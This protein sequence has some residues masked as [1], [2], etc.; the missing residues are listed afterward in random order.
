M[1]IQL[2]QRHLAARRRIPHLVVRHDRW[3]DP[4]G[5]DVRMY[6]PN[7]RVLGPA[8]WDQAAHDEPAVL[9]PAASVEQHERA[10]LGTDGHAY[11]R[12]L[13]GEHRR[14]S[15]RERQG[16]RLAAGVAFHGTVRVTREEPEPAVE[17][18][19]L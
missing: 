17:H 7:E 2:Q 13:R 4:P 11:Q 16:L 6:V 19:A 9:R 14:L 15:A 18:V 3:T 12:I 10:A 1:R 5:H 8:R